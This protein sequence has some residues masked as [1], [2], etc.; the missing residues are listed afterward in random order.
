MSP[1]CPNLYHSVPSQVFY[2]STHVSQLLPPFAP[3]YALEY[4]WKN[5]SCVVSTLVLICTLSASVYI[6]ALVKAFALGEKVSRSDG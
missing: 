5:G 2:E 6:D 4:E 3:I 1:C